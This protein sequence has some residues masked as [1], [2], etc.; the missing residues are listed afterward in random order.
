VIQCELTVAIGDP[1]GL[2][3]RPAAKIV[4]E[5]RRYA[6]T[7]RL[8]KDGTEAPVTSMVALLAMGLSAGVLVTVGAE[9]PDAEEA[10]HA[11]AE[12]LA[13]PGS[14][15]AAPA[16]GADEMAS[17][18]PAAGPRGLP[19]SPGRAVGVVRHLASLMPS[20]ETPPAPD[21]ETALK[22][23][24]TRLRRQAGE[25]KP[26]VASMLC[27]LADLALDPRLAEAVEARLASSLLLPEALIAGGE[28]VAAELQRSGD[29]YLAARAADIRHLAQDAAAVARGQV[30]TAPPPGH[31]PWIMVGS[32]L[33]PALLSSLGKEHL[34]G[35]VTVEGSP[36]SHASL[37]AASLNLPMI[38]AMPE[39]L[40][41]LREG[42]SVRIDGTTGEIDLH[43]VD[44]QPETRPSFPSPVPTFTS[45]GHR[46]RVAVN[47]GSL[48]ELL[49]A[50]LATVD[51]VGLY[52]T[53]LGHLTREAPPTEDELSEELSA[54][55]SELGGQRLVV[56]TFDFG[57]DKMPPFMT[58]PHELNPAL[59]VR[60]IRL[61]R[62][63]PELLA[64]QLR[65]V[66][67]AAELGP[68]AVMA[69]MVTTLSDVL[70]FVGQVRQHTVETADIEVGVMIEVPAAALAID[71]I[72]KYV[73]FVSVGTN[74]LLQYLNA[75]D[76]QL[77]ALADL[78]DPFTPA[79]LKLLAQICASARAT[80]TRVC[81]CG[82]AASDPDW[83]VLAVGLGVDE[84]SVPAMAV[85]SLRDHLARV[86]LP[87]AQDLAASVL[88]ADAP[89][90]V[91]EIVRG[92]RGASAGS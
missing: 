7:V 9:G 41:V 23:V 90:R 53:E 88:T 33:S 18:R 36:S 46:V 1:A 49:E 5:A 47:A 80:S 71:D 76:R 67:R 79:L 24:A 57:S 82:G 51:G 61:A 10:V 30:L 13:D 78:Q 60:G 63:Q 58:R 44:A 69:P 39:A 2:H 70:W 64:A 84:L 32:D 45:D 72:T 28:D 12:L 66:S 54:A 85:S 34:A 56:R 8:R 42:A 14:A 26:D 50:R 92:S 74:D 16:R 48:A 40:T 81:V 27:A 59:G 68:V 17:G 37:I 55:V 22:A 75:A 86:S 20:A 35:V 38:V 89:E 77:G 11:I 25:E 15:P 73:D 65:A 4:E 19:A 31:E 43:P 29:S 21:Y 3:A 52:R 6:S 87:Q 83:A 62:Q 91:R